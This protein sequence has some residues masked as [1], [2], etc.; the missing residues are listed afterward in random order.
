M[1]AVVSLGQLK[2]A[3]FSLMPAVLMFWS[4]KSC[5]REAFPSV[6]FNGHMFAEW[7]WIASNN[8]YFH[9]LASDNV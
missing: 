4:E 8:K 6:A 3:A 7:V 1:S 2:Y 5:L 9:H